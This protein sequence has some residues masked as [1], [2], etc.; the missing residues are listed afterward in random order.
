[1]DTERRL[2]GKIRQSADTVRIY[3]KQRRIVCGG[4]GGGSGWYE[5]SRCSVKLTVQSIGSEDQ[6]DLFCYKEANQL[7]SLSPSVCAVWRRLSQ[8]SRQI[9]ARVIYEGAHLTVSREKRKKKKKKKAQKSTNKFAPIVMTVML[10]PLDKKKKKEV[11][12]NKKKKN[13]VQAQR[14]PIEEKRKPSFQQ[15]KRFD[16]ISIAF[17]NIRYW[18]ILIS[19]LLSHSPSTTHN[20]TQNVQT[21]LQNSSHQTQ[22]CFGPSSSTASPIENPN[23][24]QIHCHQKLQ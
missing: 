4:G 19:H 18:I 21:T 20:I 16:Y 7:Q 23:F 3:S 2:G 9:P 11:K 15:R 12:K 5:L 10:P 1:M 17:V 8:G 14:E 6:C 24:Q 13:R 22:C